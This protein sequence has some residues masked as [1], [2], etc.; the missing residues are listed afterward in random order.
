MLN[1]SFDDVYFQNE[2]EIPEYDSVIDDDVTLKEDSLFDALEE[3]ATLFKLD[4]HQINK[5]VVSCWRSPQMDRRYERIAQS[6]NNDPWEFW[7]HIKTYPES[8]EEQQFSYLALH[9]ATIL[10]SEA[11]VERVFSHVR[12]MSTDTRNRASQQLV[13]ARITYKI[14]RD[15]YEDANS[16]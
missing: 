12:G 7:N 16:Q 4:P 5:F 11:P 2:I 3:I 13:E 1:T 10:A 14:M 6:C 9:V 8:E 15:F